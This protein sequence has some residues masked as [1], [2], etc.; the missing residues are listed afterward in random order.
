MGAG[1]A[2]MRQMRGD[3][4]EAMRAMTPPLPGE[5]VSEPRSHLTSTSQRTGRVAPL[6]DDAHLVAVGFHRLLQLHQLNLELAERVLVDVLQ[7][8][9]SA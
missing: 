2:A 7:H 4:A 6:E 1:S 9:V 3:S 5:N 8:A